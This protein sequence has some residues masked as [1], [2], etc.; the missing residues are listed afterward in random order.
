MKIAFLNFYGGLVY[1]GVETFVH[2]LANRL[3][4]NNE[5]TVYQIGPK[6]SGSKYRVVSINRLIDLERRNTHV[7]FLN[8]FGRRV[9]CFTVE[10]LKT[11]NPKT[12]IIF[13]TNGQWES[14][15]CKVWSLKHG[16]K[17]IVSGQSGPGLDDRIN[18][19]SFPDTFVALT[20]SQAK[21]A[22]KTSP[23]IKVAKIPNGVD[24]TKFTEKGEKIKLNL[25]RPIILCVAAFD[26]WKRN[27]LIIKAVSRLNEGSLLLVGKGAGEKKLQSLGKKLLPGRFKIFSFPHDQMPTVYR[28]A[29]VFT[30]ATVPWESF[31]IV[32]VEAMASGLPIVATNDPIRREIVG[33]A[34]FFVNPKN[35]DEYARVL[36][37]ALDKNWGNIPR[38]QAEKFSWNEIA[39][40][41]DQL[42]CN[43]AGL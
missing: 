19:W 12:N 27:E 10:V 41:Y 7:P 36:Q 17:M 3:S 2:E 22:K 4:E 23:F 21:W 33:Q 35:T 30:Y 34:G 40:K 14:F 43:L 28:A 24:L 20:E 6:L 9:G 31:G 13:P 38:K 16:S 29:D 39:K 25:P 32:L 1:R 8:Y 26:F 18:L 42:F 11:L 15:L 37:K 5:V